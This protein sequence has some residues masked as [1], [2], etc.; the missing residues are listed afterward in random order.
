MTLI[1]CFFLW[2]AGA[3]AGS[4]TLVCVLVPHFKDEYWLSVGYGLEQEAARQ[5]VEILF[6]EAGGYRARIRQIEQLGLCVD[7]GVD[8]ILIGAV[9]SDHPDLIQ[10]I[11]D[12]AQTTPVFS[13]VNEL[14]SDALGA[15][16]GLDWRDMGNAVGRYLAELHP[17][18]SPSRT[19]LLISGP[20]E[21]GWPSPLESGLRDGIAASS[22][23]I[24]EVSG[25]DTGL[26]QQLALVETALDRYPDVDYL[27]GSAPAIEAAMGLLSAKSDKKYP[28]LISTYISHTVLRGLMN[29]SVEAAPFDDPVLQGIQAIQQVMQSRAP[30]HSAPTG[31]PKVSLLTHADRTVDQV[32]I[33]P[34]DYFP[35]IQ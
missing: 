15:R 27:I 35:N 6:F 14:R 1:L 26:R 34:A 8:V 5:D 19:A 30:N 4:K 18:G 12:V 21:A 11:A 20:S 17:S 16:I 22:V 10:A 25:A 29:G 31:G 7:R 28:R 2:S 23:A 13:L 24:V 3:F 32:R 9:T 33:S